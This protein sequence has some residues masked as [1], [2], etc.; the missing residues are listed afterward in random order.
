M[1]CSALG[2]AETACFK[3]SRVKSPVTSTGVG[4]YRRALARVGLTAVGG[5]LPSFSVGDDVELTLLQVSSGPH[6]PD[7][8][9]ICGNNQGQGLLQGV[10]ILVSGQVVV[11]QRKGSD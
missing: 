8:T 6:H 7:Q 2:T 3:E 1:Q 9:P 11:W 10:S 4:N 5:A